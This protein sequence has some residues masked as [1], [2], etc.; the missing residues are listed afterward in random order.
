M[1]PWQKGKEKSSETLVKRQ[2]GT[3][4]S[5]H[6]SASWHCLAAC[7]LYLLMQMLPAEHP[8]QIKSQALGQGHLQG[9][10]W[11]WTQLTN[12][13]KTWV[14][15]CFS[16]LNS[17][18]LYLCHQSQVR[19]SPR[20]LYGL[21]IRWKDSQNSL[22]LLYSQLRFKTEQGQRLKAAKGKETW[23]SVQESPKHATSSCLLPVELWTHLISHSCNAWR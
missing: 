5:F 22:R 2:Q 18:H 21:T 20:S 8:W 7:L 16:L 12:G 14:T 11:S 19:G 9:L 1:R 3:F 23:R 17:H 6:S 13:V 4:S 10:R 15:Q